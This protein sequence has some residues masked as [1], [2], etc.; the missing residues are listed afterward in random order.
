MRYPSAIYL[1]VLIH[2]PFLCQPSFLSPSRIPLGSLSV[3]PF[4]ANSGFPSVWKC[5][6]KA[7]PTPS[8]FAHP[9]PARHVVRERC[10][11]TRQR[12]DSHAAAA[13]STSLPTAFSWPRDGARTPES[14]TRSRPAPRALR[15]QAPSGVRPAGGRQAGVGHRIRVST[16]P[17][18]GGRP[19]RIP[20]RIR[21][22][23]RRTRPPGLSR[24]TRP[25]RN[26][27]RPPT[28]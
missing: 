18:M 20:R 11:A 2:P 12:L 17:R 3:Y 14:S 16:R 28:A 10:G 24:G 25:C 8:V 15:L 9:E 23:L 27:P 7:E 6:S 4:Q 26:R 19:S 1:T 22:L 13:A 5:L 21:H